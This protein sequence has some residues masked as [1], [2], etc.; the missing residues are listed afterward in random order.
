[1]QIVVHDDGLGGADATDGSGLAGIDARAQR[2][3][4]LAEFSLINAG[5]SPTA[6]SVTSPSMQAGGMAPPSATAASQMKGMQ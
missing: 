4:L 1:M 2:E 5:M 3:L 6:F